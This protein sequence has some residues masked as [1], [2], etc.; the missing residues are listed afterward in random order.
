MKTAILAS[1]CAAA[2]AAC[3]GGS[4]ETEF[5]ATAQ[6]AVETSAAAGGV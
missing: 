6:A 5:N 3:G 1:L 2:L 4:D